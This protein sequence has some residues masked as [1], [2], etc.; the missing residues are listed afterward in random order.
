MEYYRTV[1]NTGINWQ[2]DIGTSSPAIVNVERSQTGEMENINVLS[3][4]R[5][6][7]LTLPQ[8]YDAEL[9]NAEWFGIYYKYTSTRDRL[10]WLDDISM[11]EYFLKI[12]SLLQSDYVHR[13]THYIQLSYSE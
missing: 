8:V 9:F 12:K 13:Y 11:M 5:N 4:G 7:S 1:L 6:H 3:K 10:L 2:N